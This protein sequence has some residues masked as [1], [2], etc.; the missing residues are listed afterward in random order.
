MKKKK[1]KI[2]ID[3]TEQDNIK[4]FEHYFNI[5]SIMKSLI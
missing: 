3:R 4:I 2:H 5:K 1:T